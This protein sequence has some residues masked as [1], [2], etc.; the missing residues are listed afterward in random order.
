MRP[1]SP[2]VRTLAEC[3]ATRSTGVDS[4]AQSTLVGIVTSAGP[5]ALDAGLLQRA[6]ELEA[7]RFLQMTPAAA[8]GMT[9]SW[10]VSPGRTPSSVGLL[11]VWPACVAAG[12]VSPRPRD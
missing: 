4:E 5:K 8:F 9:S 1:H 10:H 7:I 6:R 12:P 11:T 3:L 2:K